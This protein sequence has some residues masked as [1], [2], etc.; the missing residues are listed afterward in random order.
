MRGE[1][2]KASEPAKRSKGATYAF[3]RPALTVDCVVFGL[4]EGGL[5]VLLIERELAPFAGSWALPGGFVRVG[6]SLD[7][8]A[9]RELA[10]ETGL[11]RGRAADVF[12]EQLYSFGAPK[13]D[14]REHTVSV[15]YYAL[16]NI[17]DHAL[18]AATDARD[19]KFF[20]IDALPELAFDHAEIVRVALARLRGKLRYQPLGFELLPPR[21]SLGQLQHL[22]ETVLGEAIDKRN[23]RKKV[24]SLGFVVETGELEEDVP[25][26]RAKL[27][28]F[29]E[30]R[31]RELERDG[32]ALWL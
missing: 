1:P 13:R 15:A 19:A 21:F 17:R 6:E 8:A 12:L 14:P 3:E 7:Q 32:F 5:Q 22:Y 10:E 4:D 20:A 25:R 9:R 29:D 24:L 27:Y 23:F 28:R 16:V 18:V 30:T 11:G 31:Y 26:R 2:K